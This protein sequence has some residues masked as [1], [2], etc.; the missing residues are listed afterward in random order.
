MT[1][2][3]DASP[4]T[5][6]D[7]LYVTFKYKF[8]IVGIF[9]AGMLGAF[10]YLVLTKPSYEAVA[11]IIVQ[12]G[13]EKAEAVETSSVKANVVFAAR[14]EDIRN[15]IEILKD[16]S[17]AYAIMPE[18]KEW[19]EKA[20]RPP[21][22][23]IDHL[24]V[25]VS[26]VRRVLEDLAKEPLYLLGLATRLSPDQQ[27][28]LALQGALD[29]E[30]VEETDV[31]RLKV[32]WSNPQFAAVAA[33]AFAKEYVRRRIQVYA[34]GDAER[35]YRDQIALHRDK[36]SSIEEEIETFR[37]ERGVSNPELQR[38]LLLRE[39]SQLEREF[40]DAGV[41]I[42]DLHAKLAGVQR[43]YDG[44]DDWLETPAF[45]ALIPDLT[46]L[47]RRYFDLVADR[48]RLLET[49][50]PKSRAVQSFDAQMAKLRAQKLQSLR[51]FIRLQ[52]DG[53]TARRELVGGAIVAKRR[54]LAELDRNA[55]ILREIDRRRNLTELEY[56]E[57]AKKA[58][59]FRISQALSSERITS[60]RI[61][62]PALPPESFSKPWVSLVL[63]L[64]AFLSVF[65]GFAYAT[66]SEY[67]DHTFRGKEDVE[68]GLGVRLLATVPDMKYHLRAGSWPARA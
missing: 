31:I 2:V 47:D 43:V 38:E 23:I 39:I 10:G 67:F 40:D 58:E 54:S 33:N 42:R 46:A 24:R 65:L 66:I 35:F 64:T 15:E 22:T 32:E 13:Q 37:R 45:G 21:E 62:G 26:R 6:R 9:V 30:R 8:E 11:R 5:K 41:T 44:T 61:I 48:N 57:Y 55:R 1:R 27:F 34:A 59:D 18:L 14:P 3:S 29:A 68:S 12:L 63:G 36:L 7:I 19:L 60:V 16:K 25:W 28:A 4:V 49:D 56:S 52:A 20:Y 17:V 50:T 53:V 51:N